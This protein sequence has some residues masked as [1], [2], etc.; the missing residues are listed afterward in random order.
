MSRWHYRRSLASRVALLSVAS[1]GMSITLMALGAF[2][3]IRHQ[4][5]ESTDQ[6][7]LNRAEVTAENPDITLD[8]QRSVG[9][10]I[11]A[12]D[13]K[14]LV[15]TPSRTVLISDDKIAPRI[16]ES[17]ERV[18]QGLVPYSIR[19]TTDAKGH[20]YRIATVPSGAG[21]AV[22]LAQSTKPLERDLTRLNLVL[23]FF[24]ALGIMLAAPTGWMVA[25]NGLRPVRRLTASVERIARTE[26]LTPL[27]VEGDDEVAR[28]GGA[29]NQMLKALAASRDRQ[30]RMIAD[31][32]HELRTPLTSL[33]TNMELLRQADQHGGLP[34]DS[35]AELLDDVAAQIEELSTLVGDLVELNRDEPTTTSVQ[36]LDLADIVD[37]ALTRVRRRAPGGVEFDVELRPWVVTGEAPSLERAVT[38]LVDN[39][40]KWSPPAGRITITLVDGVLTV[41]DEGPG[42]TEQDLPHVFDRFYRSDESR[43][44]PGSGLGLSIVRQVAERHAGAVRAGRSPAGGARLQLW[45]PAALQVQPDSR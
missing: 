17:E 18:R 40:V 3:M 4:L 19:N 11:G 39:A 14:V 33:R 5:Q 22:A 24:G 45:I 37:G 29:F 7:L 1:A 34:P 16:G 12:G 41:D 9:Q 43:A 25:R 35:R 26:D 8:P 32:S 23:A 20:R 2:L 6:S 21:N 31:A 36:T 10:M 15:L 28:L 13:V 30:R 42:I 44:M 38:N 27:V